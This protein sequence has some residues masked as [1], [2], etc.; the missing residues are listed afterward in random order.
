MKRIL[1]LS[2]LL[3]FVATGFAQSSDIRYVGNTTLIS[4][5]T[6]FLTKAF[7]N[8]YSGL[9]ID[10][11]RATSVNLYVAQKPSSNSVSTTLVLA[12]SVDGTTLDTLN[13]IRWTFAGATNTASVNRVIAI[14][15]LDVGSIPYLFL[16]AIE[17]GEAVSVL[18]NLTVTYG[19]KR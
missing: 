18:T 15:N 3:A 2:L 4:G 8:V 19:Y 10:V 16:T 5:G 13:T 1:C 6:N 12:R 9:R 17:N 7:T 11:P 14:T